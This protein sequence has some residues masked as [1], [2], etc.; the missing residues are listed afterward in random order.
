MKAAAALDLFDERPATQWVAPLLGECVLGIDPSLTGFAICYS[1]P[2]KRI[3]TKRWPSKPAS[4][5][6]DRVARY[7]RVISGVIELVHAQQFD[8]I[9]IEG[10][11]YGSASR[12]QQ[13]HHDRAELGGV[14]RWRLCELTQCPIIEPAPSSLKKFVT[15]N[16]VG[17]KDIMVST[18]AVQHQRVFSNDD[19]ADAFAL[20]QLGLALTDQLPPPST[21]AGRLYL[22]TLRTKFG[23]ST[24]K[25]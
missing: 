16:G 10:Y 15:G 4:A 14:L 19:E 9:L 17:S 24:A 11:S 6:R 8:L 3:E 13:G 7:E 22:D 21:K 20:C 25:E 2:G 5:V 23:L 12:K 1:V 18:L